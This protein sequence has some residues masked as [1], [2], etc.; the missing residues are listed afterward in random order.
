VAENQ[1]HPL[2]N[3]EIA[4]IFDMIADIL[5]LKGE[6][7]HR[8]MAYRR[9]GQAIRD[10]PRDIRA[11]AA[12]DK[13]QD[14]SGVGDVL[15]EK[16]RELLDTGHLQFYDEL[17]AEFPQGVLEMLKI[18]GVGPKK[19]MQ[20]YKELGITSVAELKTAAE[21]GKLN[22]VP[23]LGKKTVDKILQGIASLAAANER[24]RI[25]IATVAAERVLNALLALPQAIHGYIGGS[26]RRGRPTIGDIDLLVAAKNED[27]AQIMQA[28][29][30]NPEVAR[31]INN[32]P[33]K[34]TVELHNGRLCDLRVLPPERYG[35]ALVYFTG[36]QL[37]NIRMRDMANNRGLVLNEWAFTPK[38]GDPEILCTTEE[39]VYAVLGLPYIPPEL[40]EERGE[41][42]AAAAGKL[43]HLIE[44]GDIKSDLHMHTTWS[45]GKLSVREMAEAARAHGLKHI[46]ITDHSVSLGVANGLNVERLRAQREEIRRVDAE[47]G[48]N[49][50][51]FQGVEL[52]IRSDGQ[53]DRWTTGSP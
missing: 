7:I 45:D 9:V 26:I 17:V 6:I 21:E 34:S 23:G 5:Q 12:E 4:D 31:V 13:L 42:E 27:A 32:G 1:T 16:I 46:V 37:H 28:F 14:I 52:E 44:I 39:E 51:V 43:P 41:F 2:T 19:A 20:F 48:P 15:E 49:F 33:T 24:V 50:R 3:R 8:V 29:I 40:R 25:D 38:N 10:L 30:T 36:S 22:N 47:M 35:T 18:N 53:L 11:Y